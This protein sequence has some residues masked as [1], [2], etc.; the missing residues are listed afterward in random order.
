MTCHEAR[1]LF[2]AQVDDALGADERRALDAHLATCAECVRELQRFRSTVALLR[3]VEP[4]QA[5]AGFVDRVLDAAQPAPWPRRLLRALVLPWPLKLPVEA[6]AVVLVAVGVVYVF[7]AT[8]EIQ[9]ATRLEPTSRSDPSRTDTTT[10]SRGVASDSP[11]PAAPR[12]LGRPSEQS[13]TSEPR[14]AP[15]PRQAFEKSQRPKDQPGAKKD[16]AP[17][18]VRKEPEP[19]GLADASRDVDRLKRESRPAPPAETQTAGKLAAPPPARSERER[20]VAQEGARL[21]AAPAPE[22]RA[23]APRGQRSPA[24]AT[25]MATARPDVAGRLA[26]A[27]RAAALRGLAYLIDRLGAVEDRRV[28]AAEGPIIELTVPRE[29]YAELVRELTRLGRWDV[30]QEAG[31]L[32]SQVR[33]VLQVTD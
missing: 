29:S 12:E 31:A 1:E 3:S 9:H 16:A 24:S 25:A 14:R 27:D 6:A 32:P 11:P 30:S 33:I 4:A 28:E 13:P 19:A 5:P 7:R 2:S 17:P 22:P 15:E 18:T 8:P 20:G 23:E 26:V 21:P 10:T